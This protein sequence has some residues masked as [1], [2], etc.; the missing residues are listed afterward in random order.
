MMKKLNTY[1]VCFLGTT[2]FGKSTLINALFHTKFDTD[3]VSACT[4]ELY[5]VTMIGD[6]PKGK[7]ALTIY[8]TPG[9][10][11]FSINTPYQK[12]YEHVINIADCVV[13]VLTFDRI[14]SPSL[15]L[16]NCLQPFLDK[17]RKTKFIIALNKID[18]KATGEKV[19]VAWDREN[20]KPSEKWMDY[21]DIKIN[22]IKSVYRQGRIDYCIDDFL[23]YEIIPVCAKRNYGLEKLKN[24]IIS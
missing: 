23:P 14:D 24:K 10:G 7:N 13:L 6:F 5:S 17:R 18:S 9:I 21:I 1:N 8:D 11:E 19:D 3:P 20:N 2:G 15:K 4:K 16:L 22:D 12:Y